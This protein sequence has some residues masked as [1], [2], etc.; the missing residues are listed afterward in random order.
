MKKAPQKRTPSIITAFAMII[1]LAG[2]A[3]LL[4]TDYEGPWIWAVLL[5]QA[6]L[7]IVLII[8]LTRLV[9]GQRDD[10]WK[11]RGRDPRHPDRSI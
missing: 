2:Q 4:F 10:Y 3:I 7:L 11:E 9:R 8:G 5:V 1:P 6:L